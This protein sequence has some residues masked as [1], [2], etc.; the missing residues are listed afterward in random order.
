MGDA[1]SPRDIE[2]AIKKLDAVVGK[3]K[4][5]FEEVEQGGFNPFIE[6]TYAEVKA[7]KEELTAMLQEYQF[8]M[9]EFEDGNL[10]I[11]LDGRAIQGNPSSRWSG[12]SAPAYK[13]DLDGG[14]MYQMWKEG[15]S[16]NKIAR[17]FRCSPDTVKRR[18]SKI[19]QRE[20]ER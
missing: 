8:Y 17:H 14:A 16:L 3:L 5:V 18:I 7:L 2:R 15:L 13:P 12:E 9:S 4:A 20:K 1:R 6:I 10:F 11:N 19:Q